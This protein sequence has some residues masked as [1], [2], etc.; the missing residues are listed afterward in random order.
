MPRALLP[1]VL[2]GA[3]LVAV[4]AWAVWRWDLASWLTPEAIRGLLD[5]SGVAAPLVFIALMATAVVFSPLPS[6][7]LD[8]AAG[9]YWGPWLGTLFAATGAL[10]GAILAFGIARLLGRGLVERVVGGHISFCSSCS[11]QLLT[12]VVLVTRLVPAVSFDLVSYGAGLT[13]MTLWRFSLATFFG[14]LPLTFLY[15]SLGPL[16][17]TGGALPWIAG[18][19]MVVLFLVL[20]SWIER[21]NLLGLRERFKHPPES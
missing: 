15:T 6:L 18:A 12:R 16:L 14:S 4:A 1:R 19:G 2:G 17:W 5:A 8:L 3:G 9:A 7:P 11:D 20:P 10:L 13:K 21:Y